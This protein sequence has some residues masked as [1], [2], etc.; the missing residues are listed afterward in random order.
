MGKALLLPQSP[1]LFQ[2]GQEALPG[3]GIPSFL[4]SPLSRPC[5]PGE[6]AQKI[7]A[8]RAGLGGSQAAGW[9]PR[10]REGNLLHTC[11]APS[12]ALMSSSGLTCPPVFCAPSSLPSSETLALEPKAFL[13]VTV[14][15]TAGS[16]ILSCSVQ[17]FL[18][19]IVARLF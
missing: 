5:T 12:L 19:R 14:F 10:L 11:P 18:A 8:N 2:G 13:Q 9:E 15:K 6:R 4:G 7:G 3:R 16:L 17:L 1:L